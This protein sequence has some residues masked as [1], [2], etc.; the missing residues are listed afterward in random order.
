MLSA[1]IKLIRICLI[2]CII[3]SLSFANSISD[4]QHLIREA[5]QGGSYVA[6]S[7]EEIEKAAVLFNQTLTTPNLTNTLKRQWDALDFE[8][9]EVQLDEKYIRIVREK[10]DK[11]F[12]RGFYAFQANIQGNSLEA[13]HTFTDLKTGEIALKLFAQ[14][15]Y[16]ASA[17]S[18]VIRDQADMAHLTSSYFMAFSQV[19]LRERPGHYL[20]QLHGFSQEKRSSS[21]G[22]QAD[23][24]LSSGA[25]ENESV[26][27]TIQNCL[28]STLSQKVYVYPKDI[29]E[30]G[31]T[32]NAINKTFSVKERKA[33]I[34][35]EMSGYM[36]QLLVSD[37]SALKKL[38][39]CL[40]DD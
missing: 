23:I 37:S 27:N 38:N 34:H 31:A 30:L 16:S 2:N 15:P 8:L 29:G 24:I 7:P 6:A 17:W 3:M 19:F 35:I 26:L 12:G 20:I 14:F 9:L 10:S 22:Q 13:P 40:S 33:F 28:L 39:H 25:I 21:L 4:L 36:R 1:G 5:Q 32:T 11:K 18:T